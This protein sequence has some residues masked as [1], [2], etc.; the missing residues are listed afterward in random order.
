MKK[1]IYF[2]SIL[3]IMLVTFSSCKKE[4][5]VNA[6]KINK[7]SQFVY[8]GMSLFYFWS[9][10]M[11][12][13]KPTLDDN[14]PKIYF[15]SLLNSLDKKE[16]WSFITDNVEEL[17]ADFSGEPKDFG[18]SV[19]FIPVNSAQTEFVAFVQYVYPNTPAANAGIERLDFIGRINDKP[20]TEN[21]YMDLYSSTSK[22]FTLFNL[23]E[24]GF[25]RDKDVTLTPAVNKTDPV[26]YTNI[27]EVG[28]K[29]IG[30]LFYTSF[31]GEYNNSLYNVFSEFKT[32]GVT[33]LVVDLRYN[34]GG[35]SDASIYLA[36]L[37]APKAAVQGKLPFVVR[38]YNKYLND[39]F[40]SKG[41]KR[42]Q[43]LGDYSA[44]SMKNPL[45]VNLDLNKVYV[46]AT[47]GSYSASELVT[48]CLKEYTDVVHIGGKTGGKFTSSFT[49][50]PYNSFGG[51]VNT[52]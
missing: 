36:S 27:Y 24:D 43:H 49:I 21:N 4:D 47:G 33:D 12:D 18:F 14:D 20:I 51:T 16:G 22:K 34:R 37:M 52:Q 45:D 40:D 28:D 41:V 46:I 23:T 39:Y 35:G 25:V 10:E 29:K 8:D 31:I 11:I 3:T 1:S 9:N 38:V 32:A 7:V 2:F 44:S 42:T 5:P 13:K 15:S 26:L 19:G 6:T 30:Y 17:L 50:N 48:Y